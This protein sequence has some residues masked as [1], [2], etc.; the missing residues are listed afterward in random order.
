M[1]YF[2]T[3]KILLTFDEYIDVKDVQKNLIVSPNPKSTPIIENHLKNVTIKLK[4]TLHP[5]TTY[6]INF[7]NAIRDVN[8]GNILK[9]FIKK[10]RS[11]PF[12]P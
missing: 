10:N 7:G 2:N 9:N 4:D 1:L 11:R 8:E 5:N 12:R 6:S 3:N